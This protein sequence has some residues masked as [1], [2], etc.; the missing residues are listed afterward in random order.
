MTET[1]EHKTAR[2][3]RKLAGDNFNKCSIGPTGRIHYE[4]LLAAANELHRIEA[5]ENEHS[6]K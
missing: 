6:S 1:P 4:Y 5:E 3:A 2:E